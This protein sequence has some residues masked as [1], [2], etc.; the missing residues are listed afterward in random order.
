MLAFVPVFFFASEYAQISLGKS[1]SRGRASCSSTSSSASSSRADRRPHARPDRSQAARSCSAARWRRSASGS[2]RA[3]SPTSTSA[4]R[5]GTIVLAGAGMGFML[6]PASTD[7]VNR[8][9]RLSYGEATGITQTVRNYSASLGL[10]I[11][12]SLLVSQLHSHL[13]T[14][15][16]AQGLPRAQAEPRRRRSPSAQ[17][18]RERATIPHFVRLDFAYATRSVLHAMAGV[19]AGA[20]S[21][22]SSACGAAFRKPRRPPPTKRSPRNR[23]RAHTHSAPSRLSTVP[24]LANAD[25]VTIPRRRRPGAPARDGSRR[26]R[27]EQAARRDRDD[28]DGDDAVQP[29]PADARRARRGRRPRGGRDAPRVQ[30]DRDLRQPDAG[31][32][33]DA[34]L[35]RQPRADRR[36]GRARRPQPALRRARVPRRVR[37]DRARRGDGA[38]PARRAGAR[39]SIPGRWRP[40]RTTARP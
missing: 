15:L 27:L 3:R 6:G 20:T 14:S 11:L 28:L 24:R 7:A 26:A 1:A 8:A 22:R 18:R 17:R 39:S 31:N 12:G 10:A 30:H 33:R 9:S 25:L 4:R 29:R 19:M 16:I 5:S 35:A 37:Q 23:S 34:R 13:T 40:A 32:A 38:P 36:L 2:G 21:S